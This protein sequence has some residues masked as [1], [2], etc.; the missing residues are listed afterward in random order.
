MTLFLESYAGG[1]WRRGTGTRHA[2]VNP[3]SEEILA[4]VAVDGIDCA[5]ALAHARD[6]GGPTL[7][8]MSFGERGALL[9][10]MAN[11]VHSAREELI[12]WAVRNGGNTRSDAKF[13]IDGAKGTL[14][15]YARL[16][17]EMGDTRVWCDGGR[18]VLGSGRR[19]AGAHV[20]VPRTGVA[21]QINAFNFP[22]WGF[23]EKAAMA[24]FAGM[25]VVCKPATSTA[26]V[27]ERLVRR[28]I[29][30]QVMPAG[31]LTLLLVTPTGLVDALQPFDV[32]A[33]TGSG[34]TGESLRAHPALHRGARLNIE[35]DS[36]NAAV[37][38]P[39]LQAGSD[40][41]DLFLQEVVREI[42]QKAG[43]KC[44]AVRR[45]LVPKNIVTAVQDDL[46][47]ALKAVRIGDP[48][49]DDT[50]MGP[51]TSS[52][53]LTD[54]RAGTQRLLSQTRAI[55]GNGGRGAVAG[56]H[57]FFM[58]PVLLVADD[59]LTPTHV[60]Q[61][62]VF[63]PVATVLPYDG[64]AAQAAAAVRQGGGGLVCSVYSDDAAFSQDMLTGVGAYHGRVH[65]GSSRLARH[66]SGPGTVLPMLLHGGPG[67]A[68]GGEELGGLRGAALYMQRVALQGYP[69]LIE[70]LC[71][72]ASPPSPTAQQPRP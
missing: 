21:V 8:R 64:T 56:E 29:D 37:L 43:Q 52:K 61:H 12:E 50:T 38:A 19:F 40:G 9:M 15:Y 49:H 60:H 14:A 30:N 31:T 27:T 67:R 63:G 66:S 53:Q 16:A 57:G 23:A 36:L 17:T 62:E 10:A 3:A 48:S 42:T 51:L 59:A 24:L 72:V 22:A 2:L 4:E 20:Y 69:S 65:F 6:V 68:G 18:E 25:P 45:I 11:A 41:Y 7:Q 33:F 28:L 34:K 71:G 44:T 32:L 70:R 5:A 55:L 54:V 58:A 39:D 46:V 1:R 13:D 35:A 26:L 47:A